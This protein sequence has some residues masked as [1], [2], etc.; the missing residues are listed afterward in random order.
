MQLT[1]LQKAKARML[2]NN[3]FFATI[4]LSTPLIA[5]KTIPTACTN[6]KEIRYNPDFF[7]ELDV[8]EVEFVLAHEVLH[9]A[10]LHGMRLMA[11]NPQLWNVAAD[12]AI[13]L[14]LQK[15]KFKLIKGVLI[16]QK[17][18]GMSAE[19]IYEKLKDEM[20]EKRKEQRQQGQGQ[21]QPG[22]DQPDP[23]GQPQD[24]QGQG[25]G[26]PGQEQASNGGGYGDLMPRD[27]L[28]PDLRP[29]PGDGPEDEA[30]TKRQVM[31]KVAQAASMARLAG[32]L[33]G[34]LERFV[35]ELLNPTV[36]WTELLRDYMQRT[37]HDDESWSRRNRRILGYYLP[38]RHSQKLGEV[39]IIGDSSGSITDKELQRI[40]SEVRA[41][42]EEMSPERIR[43][44]WADT[45]VKR[46]EV[47]E[48]GEDIEMH[49]L[50][51][52]GTDMRVPLRHVEQY[53]PV[54]VV[55]IT[56]CETPWP[57]TEPPY[58]LITISTTKKE[59]PHGLTVHV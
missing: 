15:T 30:E 25:G 45:R 27:A 46:E 7:E 9:I 38:A 58:P 20:D 34:E 16:D 44:V 1:K 19:T 39:V 42:G 3:P 10:L 21:P 56:D 36:P 12:Y 24:Q 29:T 55:L 5:D 57:A 11:R 43:M 28:G 52:G 33:T 14:T 4:L 47:F 22:Q 49:P 51:G 18:A 37:V 17:W 23:D 8:E 6:M 31:N 2:L 54:V 26:Q 32:K 53:E 41:L 59:C 13:N 40:A 48:E 50:G 35:N